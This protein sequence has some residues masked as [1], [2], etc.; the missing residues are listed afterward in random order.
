MPVKLRLSRK[1]RKKA[2]FYHIVVAD[3]RSP[4]DGKFIEKIGTY[5]P[6][7]KPATIEI[8]RNAAYDWLTKGAQPTDTVKAI[9]RF[10]GVYYRK[11]LMRGVKKGAMTVEQADTMWQTWIDAKE[12]S[13]AARRANTMAELES[14]RKMVSGEAKVKAVVA[15]AATKEA[16]QAF[17]E[18]SD[19]VSAA[20]EEEV[21]NDAVEEVAV[22][23]EEVVEVAEEPTSETTSGET[24]EAPA[25]EATEE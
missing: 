13:I 8:D 15:D 17:M 21:V 6:M 3:S 9:L 23:A 20:E 1:G 11:H 14:F 12:A 10:K 19:E 7:T 25:E 5:N 16:A 4:R 2:P 22:V 18:T 24:T